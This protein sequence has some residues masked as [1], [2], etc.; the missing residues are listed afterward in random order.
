LILFPLVV[1]GGEFV[2]GE[3]EEPTREEQNCDANECDDGKFVG[4]FTFHF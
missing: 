2:G 4:K 1:H 3:E